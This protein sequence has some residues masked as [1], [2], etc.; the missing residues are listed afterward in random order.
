[1]ALDVRSL[2]YTKN[3]SCTFK[4]GMRTDSCLSSHVLY[5]TDVSEPCFIFL[6]VCDRNTSPKEAYCRFFSYLGE[7][8][9]KSTVDFKR[10]KLKKKYVME[11]NSV[12]LKFSLTG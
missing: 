10:L 1:M 3:L 12:S 8:R 2:S 7:S 9:T 5:M 6:Q 4:S 11:I